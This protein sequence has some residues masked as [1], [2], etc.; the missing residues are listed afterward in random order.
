MSSEAGETNLQHRYNQHLDSSETLRPD[1]GWKVL[2]GRV[3]VTELSSW[4][5]SLSWGSSAWAGDVA[6]SS[7]SSDLSKIRSANKSSSNGASFLL[8]ELAQ[9]RQS[10]SSQAGPANISDFVLSSGY[11]SSSSSLA[12][13]L[14]VVKSAGRFQRRTRA[15]SRISSLK[16]PFGYCQRRG[17]YCTHWE[18]A[19]PALEA[20][21][22]L[23]GLQKLMGACLALIGPGSYTRGLLLR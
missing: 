13:M 21:T 3:L 4:E 10:K 18:M 9:L 20:R 8:L 11:A 5:H 7:P 23:S 17:V 6:L 12:R 16:C 2:P 15:V 19:S 1:L 14:L 22:D